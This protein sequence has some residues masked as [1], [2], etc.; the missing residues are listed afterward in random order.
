MGGTI[1]A[2]SRAG[3][4][5]VRARV[6]PS[7]GATMTAVFGINA[8]FKA[9]PFEGA[10][11]LGRPVRLEEYRGK[12]LVLY[13]Y[14]KSFTPGCTY[15]TMLFRDHHEQ[16]QALGAEVLGISRDSVDTQCEFAAKHEV[17]FP[18][19]SDPEGQICKAYAVDRRILPIAKRVTFLIDRE[20][21]VIGRFSHELRIS[22][23]VGDVLDALRS[24]PR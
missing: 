4:A 1:A 6:S 2:T 3:L 10:S 7:A 13:F 14:P 23:H 15:E 24:L 20:G 12:Y 9:Q 5:V 11:S 19:I 16:L 21:Y 8:R 22:A 18:M 17:R